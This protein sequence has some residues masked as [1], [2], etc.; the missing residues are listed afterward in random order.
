M[1]STAKQTHS[2]PTKRKIIIT[3][4]A[5][6][7]DG[8]E[9]LE[10]NKRLKYYRAE[11]A[12]E[13][14]SQTYPEYPA[15][16]LRCVEKGWYA[17][18][19]CEHESSEEVTKDQVLELC[20]NELVRVCGNQCSRVFVE[21]GG[22]DDGMK[23][24][25]TPLQLYFDKEAWSSLKSLHSKIKTLKAPCCNRRVKRIYTKSFVPYDD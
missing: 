18:Y 9:P 21:R 20:R 1:T 19:N 15:S 8:I 12:I 24:R 17:F 16:E 4:D 2:M 11:E 7:L 13:D 10:P 6:L 5:T 14:S 25:T 3:S 23:H 22:F